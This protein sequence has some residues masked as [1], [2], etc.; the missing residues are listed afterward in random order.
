MS[1][2]GRVAVV[3]VTAGGKSAVALAAARLL[4]ELEIVSVDAMQVYRGMDIGTAKP[5][6]A[7]RA[8]VRHHCIDLVDPD[9]AFSVA[10]FVVAYEGALAT[11]AASGHRPLLVG[12]T[13]LYLRAVTD[14][15]DL[16]GH[17]PAL[18][19]ELEADADA[20]ADAAGL[21]ERLR[22]L[23]PVA[24]ERIEPTNRRRIVRAL[25]VCIGSGR[26]F[27]SFGPGLT[28]YDAS[29]VVQLGL[30]WDRARL[31]ERITQ[32]V[33]AM[34]DA[35]LLDEVRHLLGRPGGMSRTARQA[36]GYRELIEHLDGDR[37]LDEA[38]EAI[39]VRTRQFA[40][41]QDRWF[42]RD[43]RIRWLDID[44]DPV[45]EALPFVVEALRG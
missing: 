15:L 13:G 36:L 31:A 12:G 3:G 4:G 11:I 9:V 2:P 24:A 21:Y 39:V 17:W 40:V 37:S 27:S 7:E 20:S 44:S 5:T 25:E 14:G 43:P 8:E 16:P 28:S 45:A 19:A 18:R 26:P 38:V 23:D 41:R 34:M 42:R 29:P 30:R 10:D 35:G 32:R 1:R 33:H 22:L 6:R